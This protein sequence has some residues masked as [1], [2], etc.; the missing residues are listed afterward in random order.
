MNRGLPVLGQARALDPCHGPEGLWALRTRTIV[1]V[2]GVEKE[3][4]V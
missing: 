2:L 4:V 1:S 3:Y